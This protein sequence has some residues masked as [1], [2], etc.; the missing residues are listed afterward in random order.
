MEPEVEPSSLAKRKATNQRE[1]L[2]DSGG[3]TREE[4]E[5]K[6]PRRLASKDTPKRTPARR[7]PVRP[8][9]AKEAGKQTPNTRRKNT[10]HKDRT[11][12]KEEPKTTGKPGSQGD[13]TAREQDKGISDK[14][15]KTSLN[16]TDPSPGPRKYKVLSPGLAQTAECIEWRRK[17]G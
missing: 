7:E 5:G 6:R 15:S 1:P 14:G 13:Q 10:S 17:L 11:P 16:P 2:Q 9:K 8:R 3:A 4:G 12:D